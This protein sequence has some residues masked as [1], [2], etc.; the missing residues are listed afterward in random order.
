[1]VLDDRPEDSRLVELAFSSSFP[2]TAVESYTD[3]APFLAALPSPTDPDLPGLVILDWDA[4]TGMGARMLNAIGELRH[5]VPVVV[6]SSALSPEAAPEAMALGAHSCFEK[7]G[8][9]GEL[10]D[11]VQS[12]G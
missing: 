7:P 4:H 12:W 5:R 3:E 11:W 6:M 8:T 9:F 10:L 1:M 2:A